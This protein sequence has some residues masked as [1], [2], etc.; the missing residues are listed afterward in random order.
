MGGNSRQKK[1]S[2]SASFSVFNLFKLRR[3]KRSGEDHYP[4]QEDAPIA[5]SRVWPSDED[6]G[7]WVAEPG[8]DRKAEDFIAKIHRNIA[9]DS[10][11]KT[12]TI[13]STSTSTST[14]SY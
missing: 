14:T 11:R 8:I 2:S 6:R 9:T 7:R 12:F 13:T 5:R 4:M 1:S 10:E 3:T